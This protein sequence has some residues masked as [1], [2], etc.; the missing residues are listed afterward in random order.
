VIGMPTSVIGSY[1]GTRRNWQIA[2]G[3]PWLIL[4]A[5]VTIYIV[6][7][8]LYESFIH[9][10]TIPPPALGRRRRCSRCCWS[11]RTFRSRADRHRAV[12]GH[13][14]EERHHDDRF[15]ARS[16][17]APRDVAARGDHAGPLLR[18]RPIMMTT[19]AALFGA[20]RSRSKAAPARAA[21]R[22]AHI[23]GGPLPQP[24]ARSTPR[25]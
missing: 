22:S 19:L 6:L 4:A 12:D 16:G 1:S 10:F 25:R 24:A 14:E 11:A 20:S 13:R 18:F 5:V 9:P 8:V 7:G 23:I 15:C 3:E 17:A 21:F 2:A